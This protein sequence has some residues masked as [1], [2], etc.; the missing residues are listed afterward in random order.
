MSLTL[1]QLEALGTQEITIDEPFVK[2]RQTFTGVPLATV[3][4]K[5][6]I[7]ETAT[8][9]TVALNDY[10]YSNT[11]SALVGSNAL[12]ATR[13][14]GQP[15]PYDQGGPVRLVFPDGSPLSTVLDAWNWSL[16]S[17]DV[18]TATPSS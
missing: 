14:D 4:A 5:A 2:K 7:P 15:V 6:G 16:T 8:L 11:A 18:T 1:E 10:Q 17:I 12:I 9:N 3:L 13:R